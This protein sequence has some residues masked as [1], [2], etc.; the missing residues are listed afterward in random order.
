[1]FMHFGKKKILNM[2]KKNYRNFDTNHVINMEANL[3]IKSIVWLY[4]R[5]TSSY[6][7]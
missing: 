1:M 4:N 2:D 3:F 5:Q 7:T 6:S